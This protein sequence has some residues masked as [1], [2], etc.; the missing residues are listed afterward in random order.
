EFRRVL[1]RS[2]EVAALVLGLV[3]AVAAVLVAAGVP[4]ALDRVDLVHRAVLGVVE[5]DRVED[6]ELRL[7]TEERGVGHARLGQVLLGLARDVARVAAGG[8]T[9]GRVAAYEG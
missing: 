7:R 9:G 1:F 2:R 4:P 3:A 6:V 5:A 8:G